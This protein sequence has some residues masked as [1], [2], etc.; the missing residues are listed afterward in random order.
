M[1]SKGN[2]RHDEAELLAP[3]FPWNS[4]GFLLGYAVRPAEF[5]AFAV[6]RPVFRFLFFFSVL[7]L[8]Y[9][10]M[11]EVALTSSNEDQVVHLWELRTGTVLFSY[12]GN[13]AGANSLVRLG[14]DYFI[15]A[16]DG[17]ASFQIYTWNKVLTCTY[18]SSRTTRNTQPQ[19]A[20]YATCATPQH[21]I[22]TPRN[23]HTT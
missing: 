4:P 13:K 12:K 6:L 21:A 22:R 10:Q 15:S 3:A 19:H 2:A 8:H 18:R 20:Q 14:E 5:P 16:Q 23:T 7:V 17:K 9:I 1:S 11:W